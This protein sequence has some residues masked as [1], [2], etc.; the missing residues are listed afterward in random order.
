MPA[1]TASYLKIRT[2]ASG[3]ILQIPVFT[4]AGA[5]G[6][7]VYIQGNIH[8][9]EVAGVAAAYRL[10]EILK[11]E[12][13]INGTITIVP[14]VN[15]VGL[16][17]KVNGLQV[18]Y[19]DPNEYAVGNFN[20]IYQ[21][22][23]S[24]KA[25]PADSEAPRK[26]GIDEFVA[27]HI[28]SE[29]AAIDLAFKA[30]LQHAIND[31]RAKKSHNRLRFG[32][33]LALTIQQMAHDYDYL[34]DLHTDARAI[35][36]GYTFAE[37]IDSFRYFDIPYLIRINADEFDGVLD[38]AFLIPWIK[39]LRAFK[40]AGREIAWQDIGKEVMTL[41]LGNADFVNLEDAN[42]DARRMVNYLR[43]KGVLEGDS[44]PPS[45]PLYHT[46]FDYRDNYH[47]PVGGLVFWH[48]T[49]GDQITAGDVV[50]SILPPGTGKGGNPPKLVPVMAAASGV[51]IAISR[52]SVA[53]EGIL[54]F[55]ILTHLE[56]VG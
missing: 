46:G 34:I 17:L 23:V 31:I 53:H 2:L 14:S 12:K 55:S 30:G 51:L 48:K 5:P 1:F 32:Q 42:R 10:V 44:L 27:A 21:M 13:T 7:K 54:I 52:S 49:P 50:A 56:K 40:K 8:G 11:K 33:N 16:D 15:P 25:A 3:N 47:A 18:G 38:E 22:L 4:F 9:P 29:I 43:H 28:N 37:C 39:L 26:V 20:R 6:K 41:E 19:A 36:Y 45:S 24:E 35:Y